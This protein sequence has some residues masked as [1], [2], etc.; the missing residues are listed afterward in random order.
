MSFSYLFISS[1]F[2][3]IFPKIKLTIHVFTVSPVKSSSVI[4]LNFNVNH[5]IHYVLDVY[6]Y[7]VNV[8]V[9]ANPYV[10]H[11]VDVV[12]GV[13]IKIRLGFCYIAPAILL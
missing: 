11:G 4:V 2:F 3:Y 13:P 12:Q 8:E 9:E 5:D 10:V 6:I 1:T 7:A